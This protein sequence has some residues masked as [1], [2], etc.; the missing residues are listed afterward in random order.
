MKALKKKKGWKLF[1][2]TNLTS[3]SLQ[4]LRLTIKRIN[5]GLHLLTLI[6][7][8]SSLYNFFIYNQ[9]CST[10][11]R[12]IKY[13]SVNRC[14]SEWW[15]LTSNHLLPKFSL[16]CSVDVILWTVTLCCYLFFR[17]WCLETNYFFIVRGQVSIEMSSG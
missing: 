6:N 15:T 2:K 17:H 11:K 3:R 7:W 14:W 16:S 13:L 8:I 1:P 12:G 9:L 10:T 4:N 5:L